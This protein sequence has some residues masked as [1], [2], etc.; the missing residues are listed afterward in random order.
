MNSMNVYLQ[1]AGTCEDALNFYKHALGGEIVSLK[2]FDKAPAEM[3]FV[4]AE[5]IMHAEFKADG[6]Y[7]MASDGLEQRPEGESNI[8]LNINM[9]DTNVQ[10]QIFNKL[11]EGGTITMP[12]QDT[13]WGARFG[14]F[15]DKFGIKWM[16]SYEQEQ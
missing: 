15:T 11:S 3:S 1:F 14:M 6:V 8:S 12:L 4:K 5:H 16:L 10:T 9:T 2:R 7:F 13:F